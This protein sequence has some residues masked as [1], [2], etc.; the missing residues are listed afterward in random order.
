MQRTFKTRLKGNDHETNILVQWCGISRL[1]YNTCLARWNEDYA[2]GVA[3]HNYYSIKKWFNSIK[4]ER[5]P[6]ITTCSKWVPEAAIKDLDAA[7]RNMYR[8][9]AKHPRFHRKGIRDSF[10][11]DGSVVKVHGRTLTLPKGLTLRLMERFRYETQV[12]KINNVTISR[13]AGYWFASISCDVGE[14]ARENQGTGIIGIDVGVKSLAVCSDGTVIDNPKTLYRREKRKKHLQ[15]MVAR[16]QKGSNNQRKAKAL[17]A[18]YQYRTTCKRA[19]WLHKASRRIALDNRVCFMED[20][21]VKGML[22]NHH[23]AKAVSDASFNE[24]HRQLAYKTM[25]RDIDRW[26]PSSQ[27]CSNCGNRKPM[28]LSERTYRCEQCGMVMDRDLNAALNI[29]N[30][31]MANYP[32]LMPAEDDTPEATGAASRQATAPDETGIDHQTL[33]KNRFE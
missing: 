7:F 6:F 15:R 4:R 29:L 13:K 1:A 11:I 31:G 14:P 16:K 8:H 18:R 19:D 17:L 23:L 28:P 3:R 5:F 24:L 22:A 20:L 33:R 12:N 32:E 10:R 2:N 30:V 27:I 21:N 26:Y 25:V 9:T